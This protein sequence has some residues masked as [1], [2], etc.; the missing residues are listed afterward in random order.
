MR[1]SKAYMSQLEKFIMEVDDT[2]LT[3][4]AIR[5]LH[6]KWNA[7]KLMKTIYLKSKQLSKKLFKKILTFRR[8]EGMSLEKESQLRIGNIRHHMTDALGIQSA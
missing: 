5:M 4:M 8:D 7:M 1:Q 6:A 2:E 3:K